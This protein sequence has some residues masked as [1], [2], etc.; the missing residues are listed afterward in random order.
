[1]RDIDLYT[2]EYDGLPFEAIQVKYRRKKVI[3]Q[4]I[5]YKH[6]CMLEVGC[7]LEPLFAFFN[8]FE[9]MTIVEPSS[10]FVNKAKE[11]LMGDYKNSNFDVDIIQGLLE[12]KTE[13]VNNKKYDMILVSSLLHELEEPRKVLNAVYEL[14]SDETIVHINVP[15]ARSLHRYLA[16]EMG[17]INSVYEKSE[18]QI[19][20]NQHS[21]FDMETLS[22]LVEA[23]GFTVIEKGSYFPKFFTHGQMQKLVDAQIINHE[24][25]EGIY[26][27][28]KYLGDYGSEIYVDVIKR[29][30]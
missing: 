7:G 19:R 11:L 13:V 15:N 24:M 9:E 3:E 1:M 25:L 17:L 14:C 8:D 10:E 2:K 26:K 16:F 21:T 28:S 12:E 29:K 5:K 30:V 4:I 23:C 18:Q 20:L 6:D 27:M 22:E